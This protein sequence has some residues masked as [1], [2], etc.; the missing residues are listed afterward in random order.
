M[1][2]TEPATGPAPLVRSDRGTL[3]SRLPPRCLR[4][5]AHCHTLF[6]MFRTEL[7]TC[8]LVHTVSQIYSGLVRPTSQETAAIG[9]AVCES[10][11]PRE[12]ACHAAK[13]A[14]GSARVVRRQRARGRGDTEGRQRGSQSHGG[15]RRGMQVLQGWDW[16][17]RLISEGS[18]VNPGARV[19]D[20]GP[21]CKH[22][23]SG[24]VKC[25]LWFVLC[26]GCCLVWF[27]FCGSAA[28]HL[29]VS[30]LLSVD[31][32][33]P[34]DRQPLEQQG[35]GCRHITNTVLTHP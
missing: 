17:H 15:G 24:V 13:A 7:V 22:S 27:W 25:G 29:Y 30:Y 6:S 28:M 33:Y 8:R 3:G 26:H 21:G 12:R 2:G 1:K 16:L 18:G 11:F 23:M 10:Q 5:V 20:H 9:K 14:Q 19:Q 35:P 31:T 4:G 32:G 34:R